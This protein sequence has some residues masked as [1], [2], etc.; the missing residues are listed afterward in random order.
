VNMTFLKNTIQQKRQTLEINKKL[1]H[2]CENNGI[3]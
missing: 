1:L 3:I 2:W